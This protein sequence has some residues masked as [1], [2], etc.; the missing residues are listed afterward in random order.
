MLQLEEPFLAIRV[1]VVSNAGAAQ[2]NCLSQNFLKS[3]VQ[4][5]EFVASKGG[6]SQTVNHPTVGRV[7]EGAIV[8]KGPPSVAPSS[9]L[10]LQLHQADFT[11]AARVAEVPI[12]NI[13][14][15]NGASHY[16]L[17]RTLRV[18]F[19]SKLATGRGELLITNRSRS[20]SR[21]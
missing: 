9:T 21:S 5:P 16:G 10:K 17:G 4:P 13:E 1:N 2:A 3:N 20:P 6:N 11:T 8:E 14:R 7:P 12:K 18:F 15:P 19:K